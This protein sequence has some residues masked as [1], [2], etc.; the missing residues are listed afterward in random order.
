M[1][2]LSRV[3][4]VVFLF[5]ESINYVLNSIKCPSFRCV[6]HRAIANLPTKSN[7]LCKTLEWMFHFKTLCTMASLWAAHLYQANHNTNYKVFLYYK[8]TRRYIL[9]MTA[10]MNVTT[11]FWKFLTDNVKHKIIFLSQIV[12][13]GINMKIFVTIWI[14]FIFD[15]VF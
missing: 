2:P 15:C 10:P 5:I 8:S 4:F 9:K 1:V 11:S 7:G 13:F 6:L 3:A 14:R 12:V